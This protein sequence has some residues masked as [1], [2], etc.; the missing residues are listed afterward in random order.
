VK[1]A[2]GNL[3]G[4]ARKLSDKL[5][6]RLSIAEEDHPPPEIL[7][8]AQELRILRALL[9]LSCRQLAARLGVSSETISMWERD[10][11]PICTGGKY[12]GTL[13]HMLDAARDIGALQACYDPG[14]RKQQKRDRQRHPSSGFEYRCKDCGKKRESQSCWIEVVEQA[15][16]DGTFV[17][18]DHV[19]HKN[20][21]KPDGK[22]GPMVQGGPSHRK[23]VL[24]E[25]EKLAAQNGG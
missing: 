13:K 9:R 12:S 22:C 6:E 19:F 18:V 4:P 1:P 2:L 21:S 10:D 14:P 24:D 5:R 23:A 17:D 7:A 3:D 15:M 8:T 11:R 16:I 20:K 25:R